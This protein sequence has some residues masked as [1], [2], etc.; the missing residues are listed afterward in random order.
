MM[1][2]NT[3]TNSNNPLSASINR[4]ENFNS[5]NFFNPEAINSSLA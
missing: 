1:D 2:K 3:Q 5:E 4:A